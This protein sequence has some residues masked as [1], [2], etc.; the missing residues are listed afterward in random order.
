MR[1]SSARIFVPGALSRR[2]EDWWIIG[3]FPICSHLADYGGTAMM[4]WDE[5]NPRLPRSL[6]ASFVALQI[7][8]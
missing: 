8:R 2:V 1:F 6:V 4:D 7:S 3:V 5:I